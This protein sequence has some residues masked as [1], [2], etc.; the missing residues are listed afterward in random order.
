MNM[1]LKVVV[2][3]HPL[4]AHWVTVLRGTSIP[5]SLYSTGFEELGRWLTYEA[6]RDWLPYRNETVQTALGAVEGKVIETNVRL[7]SILLLPSAL[8]LWH[9]ARKVLPNTQLCLDHVP[10]DIAETSGIIIFADQISSGEQLRQII[11]L[12]KVQNVDSRRIRVISALA[13]NH[14]LKMLGESF[15]DLTIYVASIDPDLTE[16]GQISPGFGNPVL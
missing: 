16:N 10:E 1:T 12:L 15:P 7:I 2:P 5:L 3:P 6:L 13:S 11:D 14:G 9:G 4:I 8:E